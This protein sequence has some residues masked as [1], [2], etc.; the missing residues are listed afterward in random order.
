MGETSVILAGIENEQAP[1][2]LYSAIHGAGRVMG[3]MDAK[4]KR[5]RTSGEWKRQPKATQEMM[6][7]WVKR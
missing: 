2:S 1:L 4:G 6:D 5:D 3:R 7:A